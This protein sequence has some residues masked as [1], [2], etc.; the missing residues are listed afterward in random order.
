MTFKL[1]LLEHLQLRVQH[2]LLLLVLCKLGQLRGVGKLTNIHTK[3][4]NTNMRKYDLAKLLQFP[5]I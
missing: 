5:H 2:G 1:F 4:G 3:G